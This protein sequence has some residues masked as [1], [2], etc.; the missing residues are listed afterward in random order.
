VPDLTDTTGPSNV[1][2]DRQTAA[3]CY[4]LVPILSI[5]FKKFYLKR[6]QG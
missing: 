1:F 2:T 4:A 6:A 3:I 5:P